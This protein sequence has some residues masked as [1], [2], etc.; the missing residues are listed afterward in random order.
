MDP[1]TTIVAAI[2]T[3]AAAGLKSTAE[4]A[5]KL[6]YAKV[7]ERIEQRFPSVDL[8]PVERKPDSASKR[9][10]LEED[11]ADSSA[12]EDPELLD[13]IG[14]LIAALESHASAEAAAIGIDLDEVKAAYL[15]VGNIE[16]AG[17]GVK[18]GKS[19]FSGGIDIGDVSAGKNKP[20]PANPSKR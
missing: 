8:S 12:G 10:S 17:T 6:A 3:G 13:R 2:A 20:D 1:I 14:A 9:A 4:K 19:E 5:V 11:L 16:S 7:K 18:I 15:R